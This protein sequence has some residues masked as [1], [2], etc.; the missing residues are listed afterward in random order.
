MPASAAPRI[1]PGDY[2]GD[3]GSEADAV[4]NSTAYK[5]LWTA[6]LLQLVQDA[7]MDNHQKSWAQKERDDCRSAIRYLLNPASEDYRLTCSFAGL[8]GR[9]LHESTRTK[10]I[11]LAGVY[12]NNAERLRQRALEL[13][14]KKSHRQAAA[15]AAEEYDLTAALIERESK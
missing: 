3:I 2:A 13:S 12:R 10:L 6:V 1:A 5:R 14:L 4:T 8:D 9:Q 11:S 15:D 7:T